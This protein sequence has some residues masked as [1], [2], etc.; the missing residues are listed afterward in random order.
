MIFRRVEREAGGFSAS[1]KTRTRPATRRRDG[2]NSRESRSSIAIS[3]MLP[4]HVTALA[5]M[6]SVD[7]SRV[8]SLDGRSVMTQRWVGP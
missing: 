4:S 8:T 1:G 2:L 5:P 3:S 7:A 6:E